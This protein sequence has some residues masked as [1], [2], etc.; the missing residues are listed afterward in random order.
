MPGNS[1]LFRIPLKQPA[2]LLREEKSKRDKQ[3]L[4]GALRTITLELGLPVLGK[5]FCKGVASG[6]PE[7][8][9]ISTGSTVV[10]AGPPPMSPFTP[11]R[12]HQCKPLLFRRFPRSLHTTPLEVSHS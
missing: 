6:P 11:E 5:N 10:R 2:V 8:V 7:T 4:S 12:F 9:S 3:C 1:V